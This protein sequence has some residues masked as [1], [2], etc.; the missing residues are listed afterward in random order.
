M[1]EHGHPEILAPAGSFEALKAAVRC[2]AGAVY[3][4]GKTL[5]ARRSADNFNDGEIQ[6][7]IKYCHARGVKAYITLNTLLADSDFDR[8]IQITQRA[9]ATGA[10]ALILQDLG[11]AALVRQAA[12]DMPLH[13]ST[14]MSVQTPA[15]LKMLKKLGFSR[16]ILPRELT[17]TEIV[18]LAQN[19]PLEL[20]IFVHGALCMSVSGQCYMSAMLGS[21]SGNRGL[22][23][24]PCR[25]PFGAENGTGYDLSLKD[26]SLID[27]VKD[28]TKLGIA[29]FKIEGRMKRPE[30]VAAAVTACREAQRGELKPEMVQNLQA[31]FSRSGFTDGYYRGERGRAMFGTRQKDDVTAAAPVLSTLARLYDNE[32]P[33]VPVDFAFTC[34]A[35]EPLTLAAGAWG[36][37]VFIQSE[38]IPQTAKNTPLGKETVE[39]QLQKCGGTQF[40]ARDIDIE[41]DEGLFASVSVIN[42]LRR[43]ALEELNAALEQRTPAAFTTP[44]KEETSARRPK[45]CA[46]YARFADADQIPGDLQGIK[47]II[48]PLHTGEK[49]LKKLTDIGVDTAV[50]LPRGIFGSS[51]EVI[52]LLR[53]AK[54]AGVRTACAGTLD[55][56]ALARDEGFAVHAGLGTNIFNTRA[57]A[58]TAAMGVTEA[59]LSFELTLEQ[60][61]AIGG[62]LP[63]GLIAY[64]RLPL[65]LTRN[66]PVAN[67]ISCAACTKQGSITDRMGIDF[68]VVCANGFAE[69]L[70]SRPLYMADRLTEMKNMDFIL[71]YFTMETKAECGQ[72]IAAYRGEKPPQG[73]FTRGLYYRGVE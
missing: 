69:L 28:M 66:C 51:E 2:G 25:L 39:E 26:Q 48:L 47:R 73:E 18:K 36:R 41:L 55:G 52:K 24:G 4:G 64:G 32:K 27:Y 62:T 7:A 45:T 71:L 5:N 9:C 70:N 10:D 56:I 1:S 65:M 8:A 35:G 59:S 61:A 16:A 43:E 33:L 63:R 17:R 37:S 68:P 22:C 31:V 29:S 38:T 44:A 21:R 14:Q 54:T 49:E 30:Y 11:L 57:M 19:A 23:A 20:E 3:F 72:I 42:A 34:V 12:P 58:A 13:A 15:G 60:A 40:Y 6:E 53:R 50:E 46:L 67:G